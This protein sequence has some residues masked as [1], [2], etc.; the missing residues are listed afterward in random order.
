M[1]RFFFCHSPLSVLPKGTAGFIYGFDK[2][3]FFAIVTAFKDDSSF[4][5]QN[6]SGYSILFQYHRGDG[7]KQFY[8]IQVV[9]NIDKAS[10]KMPAALWE[11][12]GWYC[13]FL[14]HD[15]FKKYGKKGTW[16]FMQDFNLLT[17]GL[18]ILRMPRLKKY[19]VSY[20][21]GLKTVNSDDELDIFLTKALQ[22]QS[23]IVEEGIINS[24]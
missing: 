8:I 21:N 12:A 5:D 22:Y 9:Q 10:V 2:P 14:D 4:E 19:L 7:H 18:Q 3:R 16:S 1:P 6:A 20:A 11:A 24:M 17:K 13:S 23:F 15:D